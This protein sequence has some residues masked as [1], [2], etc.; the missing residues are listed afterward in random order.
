[1]VCV[2][3]SSRFVVEEIVKYRPNVVAFQ[4][5]T[6]GKRFYI[7][8][9]YMPPSDRTTI[10]QIWDPWKQC[11][12]GSTPLLLGDLNVNLAH[13]RDERDDRDEETA[14]ECVQFDEA[15]GHKQAP[16]SAP[17]E[18]TM[19]GEMDMAHAPQGAGH[20]LPDRLF[21]GA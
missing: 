1:M 5:Q 9:A 13:C 11:P 12:G 7:V 2:R 19:P 6:G 20:Q 14:E 21:V 15:D 18:D 8:G 3:E 17:E 16:L 10:D 4:L